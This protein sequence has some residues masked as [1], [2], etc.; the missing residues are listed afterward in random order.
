[1]VEPPVFTEP[2]SPAPDEASPAPEEASNVPVPE[3]CQLAFERH[4]DDGGLRRFYGPRLEELDRRIP[5]PEGYKDY[6]RDENNPGAG[7][8]PVPYRWIPIEGFDPEL[9]H[10]VDGWVVSK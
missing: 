8:R 2:T 4:Y 5:D 6:Y 1:M 3:W 9:A 10:E 7:F